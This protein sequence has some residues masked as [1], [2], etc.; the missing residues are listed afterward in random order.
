MP[1]HTFFKKKTFDDTYDNYDAYV[2]YRMEMLL[3]PRV[4]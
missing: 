4:I 1:I 2:V 3:F